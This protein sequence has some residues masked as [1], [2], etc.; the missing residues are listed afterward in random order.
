LEE[1]AKVFFN[2]QG[3]NLQASFSVDIGI[4]KL[5]KPHRFDLGSK[6]SMTLIEWKSHTWTSGGNSPSAKI[7]IWNE[8][9]YFFV[10]AP[11]EFRK[12][13]FVLKS[14]RSGETLCEHYIKRYSHLIPPGV[15]IWEY[16]PAAEQP[17]CIY[18]SLPP[19]GL[20][21]GSSR[22]PLRCGG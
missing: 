1:I 16:D 19:H 4:E 2:K 8:A 5:K 13:L 7:T 20:T 11:A 14:V 9:M 18:P 3:L 21:A 10:T 15:E 12:I 17:S 6:E 22:P